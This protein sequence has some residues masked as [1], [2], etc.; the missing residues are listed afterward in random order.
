MYKCYNIPMPK[1]RMKRVNLYLL[2]EQWVWL[3][4]VAGEKGSTASK[5]VRKAITFYQALCDA[6]EEIDVPFAEPALSDDYD[7]L[8]HGGGA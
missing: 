5:Q 8:A 6:A 3:K 4:G 2:P 1:Q 7:A